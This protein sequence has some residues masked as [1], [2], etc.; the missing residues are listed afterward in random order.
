MINHARVL[1]TIAACLLTATASAGTAADAA[2]DA[3]LL[4]LQQAWATANYEAPAGEPRLQAFE[5]LEQRAGK[6]TREYPRRAEALVWKGIVESSHA[7]AKGGLGALTLCKAA[8]ASLEAALELDPRALDGSA[9]TS[10]GALYYKVPGFPIGFGDDDKAGEMLRQAL[11][12][13]P[14]GI[15][16]NYFYAEYLYEEG[17]YAEALQYLDRAAK[18]PPRPGRE[19]ADKGR[20]SEI[21]TLRQKV[22]ARLG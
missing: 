22:R 21:A 18:A 17:R 8:R 15:D 12:L 6:L 7:G 9:Y 1:A 11:Q 2:F 14:D 3:E 4:G 5:S 20:R 19:T 13:N 16:P 10:L